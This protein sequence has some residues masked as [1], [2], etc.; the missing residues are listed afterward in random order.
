[1][2][3]TEAQR[4]NF[5]NEGYFIL[6]NVI[7]SAQVVGLREECQRYIDRYDAEMEAK[8]VTVQGI[9]HY[10]KRYFISRRGLESPT[11]TDFLF[12]ELMAAIC[13]ATLGRK[14]I[15][16]SRT[17]CCQ[18]RRSRHKIR[19]APGLR[20]CRSLPQALSLLLVRSGRYVN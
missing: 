8:G 18:I 14:R 19:L 2:Q 9:N 4:L 10:K 7:P 12:G 3:I 1:M 15:S 11:I 5:R 13:K 17:V 6:E 20:L 16:V